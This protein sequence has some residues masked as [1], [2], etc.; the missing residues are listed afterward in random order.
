MTAV[1]I[2]T[3]AGAAWSGRARRGWSTMVDVL[4]IKG[5]PSS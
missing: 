2:V 5:L 1:G 4:H 3:G